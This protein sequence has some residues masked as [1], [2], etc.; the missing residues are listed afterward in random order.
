MLGFQYNASLIRE[1]ESHIFIDGVGWL[2]SIRYNR[3][4]GV[5]FKV[6]LKRELR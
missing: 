2:R 3:N 1:M 6:V 5:I 4:I